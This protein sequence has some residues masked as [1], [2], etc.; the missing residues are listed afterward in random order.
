MASR[1][2][3]AGIG[4]PRRRAL[5]IC[6]GWFVLGLVGILLALVPLHRNLRR[7]AEV[8]ALTWL[9]A[10]ADTVRPLVLQSEKR[11]IDAAVQLPAGTALAAEAPARSRYPEQAQ[12]W[13]VSAVEGEPGLIVPVSAE[14]ADRETLRDFGSLQAGISEARGGAT[15]PLAFVDGTEGRLAVAYLRLVGTGYGIS[16]S[17]RADQLYAHT[18][19]RLAAY[20]AVSVGLLALACAGLYALIAAPGAAPAPCG[21]ED[22]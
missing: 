17:M 14:A 10:Q 22:H 6:A 18:G 4:L 19:R 8:E 11:G 12:L 15:R 1:T 2:N 20:G 9:K 5:A 3:N 7:E 16:M 13:L 21:R